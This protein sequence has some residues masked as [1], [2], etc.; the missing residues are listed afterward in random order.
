MRRGFTLETSLFHDEIEILRGQNPKQHG[1]GH[2]C[3]NS[4]RFIV[5]GCVREK[6][7]MWNPRVFSLPHA[8]PDIAVGT[9]RPN[10][11]PVQQNLPG[12]LDGE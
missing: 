5:L 7:P 9:V 10:H 3:S 1:A 8:G 4:A 2:A 6:H 11:P 12:A